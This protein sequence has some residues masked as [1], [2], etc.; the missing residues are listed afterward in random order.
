MMG[1]S[2]GNRILTGGHAET[3]LPPRRRSIGTLA[4][5]LVEV[6]RAGF[7]PREPRVRV[8]VPARMRS[9]E[10]WSDI[11]ILNVSSRGLMARASSVPAARSYIEIRRGADLVIVGKV[12][13]H[14][15]C[16]FGIRTQ[17][18]VGVDALMSGSATTGP[19][20]DPSSERRTQP[21]I[22]PAEAFERSRRRAA[23]F[24]FALLA[25][26]GLACA[27]LIGGGVVHVLGAPLKAIA[28]HLG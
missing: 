1:R 11:T 22:D 14:D 18:R 23:L 26:G 12:I 25:V 15:S 16:H 20:R 27:V 5:N 6:V 13:W 2:I 10:T 17:D 19:R 9:G 21:R 4:G 3:S 28:D 7:R 8:H 24:Q